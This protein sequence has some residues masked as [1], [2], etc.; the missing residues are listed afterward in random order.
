MSTV[1]RFVTK[2]ASVIV[3]TLHCFDRVIFKGH[4]A[5]A[6]PSELERFV[7]YMLKVRRCHFMNVLAPKY[8]QGLVEHAQRFARKAGRTYLYRTGSFHKDQWA[9]QLLREDA[10]SDTV[11][12]RI[13]AI[14]QL[15]ELHD[16]PERILPLLLAGSL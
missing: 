16:R 5:M 7:D 9:E 11:A 2:F 15:R 12:V 6:A 10:R 14:T 8:S 1:L 4:L 3:S 13:A